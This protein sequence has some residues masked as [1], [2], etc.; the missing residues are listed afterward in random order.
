MQYIVHIWFN[1]ILIYTYVS[2]YIYNIIHIYIYNIIYNIIY[3][4]IDVL[5][6]MSEAF[7]CFSSAMWLPNKLPAGQGRSFLA[8][9]R[10]LRSSC[11]THEPWGSGAWRCWWCGWLVWLDKK[12]YNEGLGVIT[13]IYDIYIYILY[14]YS[15]IWIHYKDWISLFYK[16]LCWGRDSFGFISKCCGVV[17]EALQ[18]HSSL[19]SFDLDGHAYIDASPSWREAH[20]CSG[21]F[22]DKKCNKNCVCIG[23][24]NRVRDYFIFVRARHL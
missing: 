7:W 6:R 12:K 16:H 13:V 19:S 20:V 2:A 5:C 11:S 24:E 9:P 1:H 22:T 17:S 14:I 18:G 15:D 3:I 10:Q 23:F 8:I 21:I 4:Y